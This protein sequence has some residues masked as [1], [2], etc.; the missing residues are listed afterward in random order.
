[1]GLGTSYRRLSSGIGVSLRTIVRWI[2]NAIQQA[3]VIGPAVAQMCYELCPSLSVSTQVTPGPV[4]A[5]E[6]VRAMLMWTSTWKELSQGKK[7]TADV[8]GFAAVNLIGPVA[9]LWC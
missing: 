9:G 3:P 6:Q 4:S 8:G 2:R 5:R 1:M 7:D